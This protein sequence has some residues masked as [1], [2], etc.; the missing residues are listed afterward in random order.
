[1]VAMVTVGNRYRTNF[2]SYYPTIILTAKKTDCTAYG[3][4]WLPKI[5]MADLQKWVLSIM[6]MKIK[7]CVYNEFEEVYWGH[8]QT[9]PS[10]WE[11]IS[12]L[13]CPNSVFRWFWPGSLDHALFWPR[14][15]G[16]ID[17]FHCT[18]SMASLVLIF[19]YF[20][21]YHVLSVCRL[22]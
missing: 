8:T 13:L 17:Q 16:T 18:C 6:W 9:W 14:Y 2:F 5:Q 15:I 4:C 19:A 20:E 11:T 3:Y 10:Y 12:T 1:M 22:S 21:V 7:W